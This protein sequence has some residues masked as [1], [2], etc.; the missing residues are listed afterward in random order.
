MKILKLFCIILIASLLSSKSIAQY[1]P[2]AYYRLCAAIELCD[3]EKARSWADSCLLLKPQRYQYLLA[4]GQSYFLNQNFTQAIDCFSRVEQQR[5]GM[6]SLWLAKTYCLLDD[7]AASLGYLRKHLQSAQRAKE[8]DILLDPVFQ[9]LHQTHG[10]QHIWR[11]DWYN[12]TDKT[13]AEAEYYNRHGN[14]QQTLALLGGRSSRG[15]GSAAIYALRGDAYLAL[16]NVGASLADYRVALRKS[17]NK[18]VYRVKVA[19]ALALRAQPTAAIKQIDQAI[20][21]AGP[22]PK[23]FLERAKIFMSMGNNK[24]AHN[25]LTYY[26][27]FYPT[28]SQVMELFVQTAI[29]SARYV[30]ALWALAKLLKLYPDRPQLLYLRGLAL[31]QTGQWHPAIHDFEHAIKLNYMVA[32]AYYHKALALIALGENAEA[33]RSFSIA[34]HYGC[35]KAQEQ[36]YK[37]CKH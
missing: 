22:N 19:Q 3:N 21:Q 35:F 18:A 23:F 15:K 25:D 9:K 31:L 7:T 34:S 14:Y 27:S 28:D 2:E 6:G 33:C 29:E 17:R 24:L 37:H 36:L 1:F 32:D 13:L 12:K 30:D 16:K 26:L 8:S 5:R 4:V 11:S 20:R 10:W